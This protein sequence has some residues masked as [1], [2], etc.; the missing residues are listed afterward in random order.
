MLVD[1][2]THDHFQDPRGISVQAQKTHY[3]GR[4]RRVRVGNESIFNDLVPLIRQTYEE[5]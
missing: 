1:L 4:I 3:G 5:A 2:V